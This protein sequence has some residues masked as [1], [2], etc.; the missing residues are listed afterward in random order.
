MIRESSFSAV[1]KSRNAHCDA[2]YS[3][4][5]DVVGAVLGQNDRLRP[6]MASLI[7]AVVAVK[8]LV[9]IGTGGGA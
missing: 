7:Q 6:P 4:F 1:M 5:T 3:L 9:I 8:P 2:T